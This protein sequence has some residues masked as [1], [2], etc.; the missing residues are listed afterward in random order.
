MIKVTHLEKKAW[1][2]DM[3]NNTKHLLDTFSEI[4]AVQLHA[5][6]KRLDSEVMIM[7]HRI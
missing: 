7:G 3:D 1:S 6:P 2:Y 5:S 4:L